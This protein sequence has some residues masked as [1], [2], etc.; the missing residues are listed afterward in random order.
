MAKRRED[1]PDLPAIRHHPARRGGRRYPWARWADGAVWEIFPDDH[2]GTA[3]A[4]FVQMARNYAARHRL[5]VGT[6]DTG[7]GTI[8]IKFTPDERS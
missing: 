7:G 5:R 2:Q 4:R 3:D 8:L 6:R 1:M